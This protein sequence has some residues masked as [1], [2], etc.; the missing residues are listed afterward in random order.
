MVPKTAQ[1]CSKCSETIINRKI[2][3]FYIEAIPNF[4]LNSDKKY[5][6]ELDK[7]VIFDFS[8]M[9]GFTKGFLIRPY[10]RLRLV[11]VVKKIFL[12]VTL[13]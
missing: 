6:F 1:A 8:V 5:F 9:L 3:T 7:N 2:G 4:F 12:L 10:L 13:L 11:T